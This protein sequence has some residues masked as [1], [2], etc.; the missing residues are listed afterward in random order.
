M[1]K[2]ERTVLINVDFLSKCSLTI[3]IFK[4]GAIFVILKLNVQHC[5][6]IL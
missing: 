2:R 1:Y 6:T 5:Y 4:S 3:G